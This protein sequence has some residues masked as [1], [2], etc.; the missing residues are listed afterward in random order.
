MNGTNRYPDIDNS[1][2]GDTRNFGA[3]RGI[4][5]GTLIHTTSGTSSLDWLLSGSARAGRPASADFLI[6]RDGTRHK[7]TRPGY[8]P[9]HAGESRYDIYGRKYRGNDL[10]S[11]LLGVELENRDDQRC[12]YQQLD[13]LAE[14][15]VIVGLDNSWRWPYYLL[16]HYEVA[17]P[18]G[19]RSD[20]QGFDW[21][22]FMGRLYATALA[23][24]VPGL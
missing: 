10:S 16:G 20:P 1:S 19:R 14:L 8:Y 7:L 22:D 21:G 3:G 18:L 17:R 23:A 9:Y 15:L 11:I 24:Q 12:T 5:V 6:D 4:I 2:S 13:S